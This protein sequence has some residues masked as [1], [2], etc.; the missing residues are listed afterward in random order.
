MPWSAEF[1]FRAAQHGFGAA[2]LDTGEAVSANKNCDAGRG[3]AC[4][5]VYADGE[6]RE[7]CSVLERGRAGN[8]LM[9]EVG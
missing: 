4:T 2:V 6:G 7:A 3:A 5:S 9:A 8:L 1:Q